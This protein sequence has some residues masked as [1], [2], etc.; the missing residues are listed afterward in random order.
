MTMT[1]VVCGVSAHACR[2]SLTP[3]HDGPHICGDDG[4]TW[5]GTYGEASF[6]VIVYPDPIAT[7]CVLC[8]C[9]R[10]GEAVQCLVCSRDGCAGCLGD[11]GL[12]DLCHDIERERAG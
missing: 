7:T 12:C 9:V 3:G 6:R 5:S 1:E 11:N 8:G 10:P 4:G 2:C